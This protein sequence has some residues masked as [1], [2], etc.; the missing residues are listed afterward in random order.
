[1]RLTLERR[2][3]QLWSKQPCSVIGRGE[4]WKRTLV[5]WSSKKAEIEYNLIPQVVD[6]FPKLPT[7]CRPGRTCKM[8]KAHTLSFPGHFKSLQ[9]WQTSWLRC[10]RVGE[11]SILILFKYFC[12]FLDDHTRY[13]LLWFLQIGMIWIKRY[14]WW[15]LRLRA[16]LE[17]L[18][19]WKIFL[20]SDRVTFV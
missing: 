1:M 17:V 19:E 2:F 6:D 20:K 7:L 8:E 15:R 13:T 9:S 12:T 4:F 16:W 18:A 3:S 14:L 5:S 10:C 11:T